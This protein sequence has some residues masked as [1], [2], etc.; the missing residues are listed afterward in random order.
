M[1]AQ[2]PTGCVPSPVQWHQLAATF[3]SHGHFAFLDAAY[4]GFASSDVGADA[5]SIRIFTGTGVPLL[6]AATYGKAFGLYGERIR[7]LSVVAPDLEVEMQVEKQMKLLAHMTEM[8]AMPAFG[9]RIVE[10]VLED[11]ELRQVW[12]G[13]VKRIAAQLWERRMWLRRML[14]DLGTPRNWKHV[15][16]QVGMFSWVHLV[17]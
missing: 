17:L 9:M 12:E 10:T 16:D 4:L 11:A 15:M 8:G 3:L 14:E 2:N 1:C 5:E 13:D 6:L 7:I